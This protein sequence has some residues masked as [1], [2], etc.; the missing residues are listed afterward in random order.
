[1]RVC[2]VTYMLFFFF[3]FVIVV[4]RALRII[5]KT[6]TTSTSSEN[7]FYQEGF[8]FRTVD[9]NNRQQNIYY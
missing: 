3:P 7:S 8:K 5:P 9:Y 4:Q 1:M 2:F 6:L